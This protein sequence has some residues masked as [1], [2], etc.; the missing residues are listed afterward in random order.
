M[1]QAFLRTFV[2]IPSKK[3]HHMMFKRKGGGGKGLLNNVQK[4]ALFSQDGFPYHCVLCGVYWKSLCVTLK[5]STLDVN[6]ISM[7]HKLWFNISH[8]HKSFFNSPIQ[9]LLA[10]SS[11]LFVFS[12]EHDLSGYNCIL[13]RRIIRIFWYSS[14]TKTVLSILVMSSFWKQ[15][16]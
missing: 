9:I 3:I 6:L 8:K 15:L 12:R 10:W 5:C 16:S 7:C 14:F 2:K 13:G 1:Q 4:T 11:R